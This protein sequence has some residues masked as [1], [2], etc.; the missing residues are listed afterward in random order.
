MK[1]IPLKNLTR[2]NTVPVKII[3]KLP[4]YIGFAENQLSWLELYFTN[5]PQFIGYQ[6]DDNPF[7]LI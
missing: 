5:L 1:N 4:T 7:G 6:Y 2:L 3:I